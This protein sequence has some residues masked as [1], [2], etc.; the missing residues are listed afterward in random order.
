MRY[1]FKATSASSIVEQADINYDWLKAAK[2][3]HQTVD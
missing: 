2:Q 1:A 3:T